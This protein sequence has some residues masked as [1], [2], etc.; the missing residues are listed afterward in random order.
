M[1]T[2]KNWPA[3]VP[4]MYTPST[5]C[6]LEETSQSFDKTYLAENLE[7]RTLILSSIVQ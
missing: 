2:L 4:A 6:R 3:Y 1:S 5:Y 7:K